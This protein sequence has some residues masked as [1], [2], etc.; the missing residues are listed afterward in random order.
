VQSRTDAFLTEHRVTRAEVAE[1][2][3]LDPSA[4]SRK[5]LGE[6][7]WKL[8]EIQGLLA[9]LTTK[10]ARRVSYEELVGEPAAD[11]V[12]RAPDTDAPDAA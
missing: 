3:G 10:L 1:A 9:Y 8:S 4:V 5:V 7:P 11:L 12:A 6:R 2:L